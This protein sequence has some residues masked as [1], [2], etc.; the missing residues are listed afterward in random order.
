MLSQVAIDDLKQDYS[1]EE[2]KRIDSSLE[3]F[4]KSW[5]SFSKEDVFL[6]AK[7]SIFSKTKENA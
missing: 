7:Q 1:F 4:K 2:I 6:K 3:N 5:I